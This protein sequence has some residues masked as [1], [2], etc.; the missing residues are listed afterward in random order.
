M[1]VIPSFD[2]RGRAER[3]ELSIKLQKNWIYLFY[4]ICLSDL[5]VCKYVCHMCD[6]CLQRSEEDLGVPG[7]GAIDGYEIPSRCW[8]S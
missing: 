2:R 8:E 5:S 4:F 1:N 3:N 7:A 6:R